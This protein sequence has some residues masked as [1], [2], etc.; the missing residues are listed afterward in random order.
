MPDHL[1]VVLLERSSIPSD[2][3]QHYLPGD[4]PP[5]PPYDHYIRHRYNLESIY[6]SVIV[7]HGPFLRVVNIGADCLSITA[8]PSPDAD[9]LACMAE[10][11]LLQDQGDVVTDEGVTW[12]KA[13]TPAGVVGWA[14]GRYLE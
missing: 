5:D 4:D 12:H 13:K 11:V 7:Q 14:D 6:H 1:K 10:R 9:E 3:L 8:E 2:L